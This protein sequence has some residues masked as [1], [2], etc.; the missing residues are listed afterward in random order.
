MASAN[1][2]LE[3]FRQQWREEV[4]RRAEGRSAASE[5]QT[6]SGP[7][8]LGRHTGIRLAPTQA[9]NDVNDHEDYEPRSFHDLDDK[10]QSLTLANQTQRNDWSNKEPQSALDHYEKAVERE[11]AGKLGDSV[12]LYRKAY[13]LDSEVDQAYKQKHFSQAWLP[14]KLTNPNASNASATIPSTAHHSLDGPDMK[15]VDMIDS[16][17]NLSIPSIPP[18]TDLSPQPPCPI[19][20]LPQELLTE[21]LLKLATSD[22]AQFVRLVQVCKSLAY[23]VLTEDSIWKRIILGPEIG[24]AAM[25]Y[26]YN[27]DIAGKPLFEL[28]QYTPTTPRDLTPTLYSTYLEQFRRRPRIRFNGCY[29][30]TVNY[31]RPG[32][33]A[34]NRYNWHSPIQ[35]VT[36]Y[37]YLRFF[38]DGT[39][40][41]LLTT[42]EPVDVVHHLTKVNLRDHRGSSL[43]SSV[44]KDALAGRWRLTGPPDVLHDIEN[45]DFEV[46]HVPGEYVRE[47]IVEGDESAEAEGDV[48]VETFGATSKYL[49]K[50]Q[51]SLSNAG[52]KDGAKNNKLAWKGFWSYNKLTDDWGE[53]ARRHERAFYWSR[54]KSYGKSGNSVS[55]R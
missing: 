12:S 4:T 52:R 53:F 36:Y 24:I 5:S 33:P 21:V 25:L 14:S 51:M 43:P 41:S 42:A 50:M 10:E 31:N 11:K 35:V 44:M 9:L 7:V 19:S 32:A 28:L 22:V 29:I 20:E 6:S 17:A 13:R 23:F 30:S 38:R 49:F 47:P 55:I 34:Q 18:E 8:R 15:I 27:C 45:D 39:A 16:F 48:H 3:S 40:I 54:V 26:H 2:D 37:R 1:N 46:K